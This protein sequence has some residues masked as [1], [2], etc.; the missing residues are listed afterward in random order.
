[1]QRTSAD[2]TTPEELGTLL[3]DA[4]ITRDPAALA[5]L[6]EASAVLLTGTAPAHGR[7][8]I[9]RVALA[10]WQGE[11]AYVAEPYLVVQARDLALVIEKGGVNVA[12][13][14]DGAWRYAIVHHP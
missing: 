5:A 8:E 10:T 12:R 7:E 3:E 1:M 2:A 13:R 11:R 6:F 4:L 9:A 14:I